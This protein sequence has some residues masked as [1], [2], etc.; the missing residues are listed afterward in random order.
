MDIFA[1]LSNLHPVSEIQTI[2]PSYSV[3]YSNSNPEL[4]AACD[5]SGE[6]YLVKIGE[7]AEI[8]S[9]LHAHNNSI[10]HVGWSCDDKYLLTGSGDQTAGVWDMTRLTGS[11]LAKH[12]G[13]VKCIKNSP[14]SGYVYATASR[15]GKIYIWDLRTHGHGVSNNTEFEPIA[16]ITQRADTQ[17]RKKKVNASFTGLEYMN[18]GNVI[19]S[20]QADE[21]GMR[22]WD[23]RRSESV[24]KKKKSKPCLGIITPL[25]YRQKDV[26]KGLT[27]G[28]NKPVEYT[29]QKVNDLGPGNS[30]IS[31][32]DNSLLVSSMSNSMYFYQDVLHLDSEP[33]IR[34]VGHKTSFYVKACLSPDKEFAVSGSDEGS[35]Y[36]WNINKPESPKVLQSRYLVESS[37]VDWTDSNQMFLA[38]SS[39]AAV[40]TFWDYVDE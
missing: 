36:M 37:C 38:S 39:D 2:A 21:I 34:F 11:V 5:E 29:V 24:K 30:W 14:V 27:V 13:S 23:I 22:F 28:K 25:T 33:P 7:L 32:K 12:T 40:V 10:F 20:V 16:E 17:N 26:L 9:Q 4:F 1:N 3:K 18:W 15:D 19:V 31:L 6:V 8:T 35:L